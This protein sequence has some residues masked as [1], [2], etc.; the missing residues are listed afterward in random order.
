METTYGRNRLLMLLASAM[1]LGLSPVMPGTC[2]ALLGVAIHGGIAMLFPE[3]WH[4]RLLMFA[5]LGVSAA[6]VCLTPWAERYWAEKDPGRFV[7][8]EVAGYLLVPL[9]F[10]NGPWLKTALWG[11]VLFRIFDIFKLIPPAR[12]VDETVHGPW[13]V[14]L[15]DLISAGYA[16]I[17]LYFVHWFGPGW[18]LGPS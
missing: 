2:G 5:F 1:G 3:A 15:D 11:F 8:D 17:I 6:S 13:G 16:A 7:L 12:L 14:L 4:H 10:H 9:L 18:V